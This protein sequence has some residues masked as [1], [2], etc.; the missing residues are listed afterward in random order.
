MK[1][2][3]R[4]IG[5]LAALL[6]A[7]VSTFFTQILFVVVSCHGINDTGGQVMAT[8]SA[9]GRLCAHDPGDDIW[10]PHNAATWAIAAAGL[11]AFAL[12]VLAWRRGGVVARVLSVVGLP[13]L[14]LLLLIPFTMPADTCT[15]AEWQ[16]SGNDCASEG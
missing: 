6:V 9:Q 3:W 11:L 13:V 8:D 14:P 16:T 5:L 15:P 7:V 2:R 4:V 1:T 10:W 12:V